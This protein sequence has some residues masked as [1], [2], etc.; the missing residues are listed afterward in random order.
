M[1]LTNS[2]FSQ[3]I[4]GVNILRAVNKQ[5]PSD[6]PFVLKTFFPILAQI[7]NGPKTIEH[8]TVLIFLQEV[9]VNEPSLGLGP[10]L[11]SELQP[12]V[13]Q[14]SINGKGFIKILAKQLLEFMCQTCNLEAML[15]SLLISS[16]NKNSVVAELS[17]KYFV[18]TLRRKD[19][20]GMRPTS[21]SVL[22]FSK[23]LFFIL[24]KGLTL[25]LQAKRIKLVNPSEAALLFFLNTLGQQKFVFIVELMIA[26]GQI[27]GD[28]KFCVS[29]AISNAQKR[30]KAREQKKMN[31][32]L[33]S[34]QLQRKPGQNQLMHSIL[35]QT[36]SQNETR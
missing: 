29:R 18:R 5:S 20:P 32:Q 9:L 27:P 35:S 33:N 21:E 28:F 8:K 17:M 14:K 19:L 31:K 3:R 15:Y 6:S 11:V 1:S 2:S 25:N 16:G 12:L 26:E 13:A 4:N 23:E 7:L 34:K 10:E 22:G 24:F 36:S 30:A